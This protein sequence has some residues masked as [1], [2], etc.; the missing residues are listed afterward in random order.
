MLVTEHSIIT[1]VWVEPW[2]LSGYEV[3]K[4]VMD[5]RLGINKNSKFS[6]VAFIHL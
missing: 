1:G 4:F 2:R 5:Y 6:Q 3:S